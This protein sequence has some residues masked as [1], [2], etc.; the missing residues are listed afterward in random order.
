[1]KRYKNAM[2]PSSLRFFYSRQQ[3]CFWHATTMFIH[4]NNDVLA[5]NND[6]F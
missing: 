4:D 6:V 2:K 1:M 5:R 3:R